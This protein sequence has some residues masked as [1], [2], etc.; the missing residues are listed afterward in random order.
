M[1]IRRCQTIG[2]PKTINA[3]NSSSACNARNVPQTWC[4]GRSSCRNRSSEAEKRRLELRGHSAAEMHPKGWRTPS[5]AKGT[6][7]RGGWR[8]AARRG[9]SRTRVRFDLRRVVQS[10]AL[11]LRPGTDG[12]NLARFSLIRGAPLRFASNLESGYSRINSR[13]IVRNFQIL[14]ELRCN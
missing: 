11:Q 12:I 8:C 4:I 6:K 2:S 13:K 10:I 3:I 5:S 14:Y 9:W 7:R 1:T